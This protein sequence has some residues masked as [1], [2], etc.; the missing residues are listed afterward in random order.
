M[1]IHTHLKN[2]PLNIFRW[3]HGHLSGKEAEIMLDKAKNGSFLVRESQSK[4]GDY[5]LSVKTDDKVRSAV[6]LLFSCLFTY[7]LFV[8]FS[9]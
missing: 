2:W 4:P 6:R 5:V 3:F 1:L 8:Y 9:P 7:L